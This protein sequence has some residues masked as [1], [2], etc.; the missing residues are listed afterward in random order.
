MDQQQE[1]ILYLLHRY[2]ERT[3]TEEERGEL[4]LWLASAQGDDIPD[5][6][7]ARLLDDHSEQPHEQEPD[8]DL[9]YQRILA[10]REATAPE[11][12]TGKGLRLIR[13]T[14]LRYAAAVLLMAGMIGV[15]YISLTK[16]S[17]DTAQTDQL[18]GG[19]DVQ[20]G[21][22]GA[23]LVLADGSQL[24][25]DSLRNGVVASQYGSTAVLQNGQLAYDADSAAAGSISY[26]TLS[27]PKGRQ[28]KLTLPDGTKAWLNAASYIRFPTAFAGGER[29]VEING[30]VYLEVAKDAARPFRVN[31]PGRAE[32]EVLGTHFNVSAYDNDRVVNTTLLEGSVS[33]NGVKIK[34]G[35]QALVAGGETVVSKA[36]V[37]RAVAWKNG[38]FNFEGASLEEVMK[39]LERWYDIEVVYAGGIPD[40]VF[41][42]EMTK[43]I[44]LQGLLIVLEKSDVNFRL[45]GRKLIVLP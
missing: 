36:D 8:W 9:V 34:P 27:T 39:Q 2:G 38:L 5:E 7:V 29:K 18:P 24:V 6:F 17:T 41:G 40:I 12:T 10:G 28:F 21:K 32:I 23:V 3:A 43:N 25:L 45:E 35:Q 1:R 44:S 19:K 30:E 37:N 31:V 22:N 13:S 11:T 15:L 42:G 26:N 4:T 16:E 14:W 33:V 20:P